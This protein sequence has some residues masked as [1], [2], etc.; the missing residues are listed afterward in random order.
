MGVLDRDPVNE[1]GFD[2]SKALGCSESAQE[3][4]AGQASFFYCWAGEGPETPTSVHL[5]SAR[6]RT[7][8]LLLA[9]RVQIR[10][11]LCEVEAL[12]SLAICGQRLLRNVGY[13]LIAV[14]LVK[15]RRHKLGDNDE[16]AFCVPTK[17]RYVMSALDLCILGDI[18]C[19]ASIELIHRGVRKLNSD[20]DGTKQVN[21]ERKLIWV[22]GCKR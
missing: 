9:E 17:S 5:K 22:S 7:T 16:V 2:H 3:H 19:L 6:G 18:P 8:E 4:R 14:F 20:P 12:Q 15:A 10:L 21:S 1:F 13:D 11:K